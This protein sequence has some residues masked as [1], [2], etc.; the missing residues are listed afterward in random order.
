MKEITLSEILETS[1]YALN[2]EFRTY[3]FL[4]FTELLGALNKT[5]REDARYALLVARED[6]YVEVSYFSSEED[7]KYA[8]RKLRKISRLAFRE[9]FKLSYK[10]IKEI[11]KDNKELK[12]A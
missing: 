11:E 3:G 4:V 10:S 8:V 1:D 9:E 5:K 7:A 12:T 2:K 6:A